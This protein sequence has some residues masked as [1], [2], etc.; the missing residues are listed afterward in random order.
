M[1]D[2]LDSGADQSRT[3]SV[4]TR[5]DFPAIERR[6]LAPLGRPGAPSSARS[7]SAR[8][9]DEYVFYDGPPF[10]NG[11]PHYGHL[12]TG[13]VKDVV[14]RYQTMRGH[15][16]ERRFGWDCHG[17]PAEMETEKELGRR[18]AAWPSPTT[19]ST[20]STTHCRTSVLRY[21]G[22]WERYVTRQ[23]RW[24][25]FD[26]DYKT[27]DASYMESVI[28]AFKQLWDK[29]LIYEAYRVMPYSWGAETPLSNFEIRL[30][31]ATRPR[32]DPALTVA[33]SVEAPAARPPT[34]PTAWWPTAPR[35][36]PGRPRRGRCRPTWR[37]PS[38]PTSTTS[39]WRSPP[40]H[41]P[42]VASCS[43]PPRCETYR[44]RA[45]RGPPVVATLHGR[46]TSS[47]ARYR[48]L[49]AYFADH[50][51][52]FR[53]LAD[54]FVTDDDGTGVVH[55]APG[56]GEDDQRVCEAAGIALVVPGRR[57]GPLHRRGRRL[58]RPERL[59]RQPD[60]HRATSR[61]AASW[62][63]TTPTTTTTRTAGAPT[64]RSSTRPCRPGTSRS[65]PSATAWSS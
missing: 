63:A 6:I 26:D 23:A 19:A 27:M 9:D 2:V 12:L 11:L 22:E 24:V 53:V 59:R 40:D 46:A 30:D 28:W 31:D 21:T 57:H 18:P 58:R 29:G 62:C 65:P 52:S 60:D 35:S 39:W 13:Y 36:G 64:R 32:Q 45:R 5:A 50:A 38:G 37:S 33:F 14:P 34:C 25:D 8:R 55:M 17:L 47:G 44:T 16:V 3:P 56:F 4:P 48:P 49:F 42:D 51:D 54:D 43:A 7:S 41:G 10:A 61:T 1:P 20:G 15:R